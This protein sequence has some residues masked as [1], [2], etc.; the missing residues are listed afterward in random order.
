VAAALTHVLIH[1]PLVGPA[2]WRGVAAEIV[3]SGGDAAVP[4][5]LGFADG[6]PPYW[7]AFVRGVVSACERIEGAIV[8]V[9]H[10]GAGP[11]VPAMVSHL[12]GRVTAVV[13][14]DAP[15][16]P[17]SGSAVLAPP[18]LRDLLAGLAVDGVLPPWSSW[19][20]PDA[21]AALVPDDQVRAALEAEM[22]NLPLDYFDR[23]VT[24]PDGWTAG[25]RNAYLLF[26]DVYAEEAT[27]AARRGWPVQHLSGTHLHNVTH[28]ASV[29]AALVS[30][31]P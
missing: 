29:A 23:T 16:P 9:V 10:S 17:E 1:S 7:P 25:V 22:P 11:L 21:L 3:A 5:M 15:V 19:W 27:E 30:L 26:S 28:P 20:G 8:L 14:A 13:F 2:T 12:G 31:A 24:V 6:G 4:S 18:Q